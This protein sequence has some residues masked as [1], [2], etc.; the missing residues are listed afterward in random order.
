MTSEATARAQ[1]FVA[2][3]LP[4][5]RGL[6]EGLVELIGYPDEFAA[7][8]RGGL[9]RLADDVYAAEQERVAPG[10]GIVFGVRGPLV[11]AVMRQLRPALKEGSPA[12]A[13]WLAERLAGEEE[14]EFVFFTQLALERALPVDPER[15]WQLMRRLAREASDWIRVDTLAELFAK[16]ILL[17]PLRWAELEQLVYSSSRWE[18]RLVG[19]T[20]ARLP[21]ELPKARRPQL[22]AVPGLDAVGQLIGDAEPDVQKALSWALRSWLEVDGQGVREFIRFEARRS[23]AEDDGHRAWVLRDAL[24]APQIEAPFAKEIRD[25]LAAVRRRPGQPSTS[26]AAAIAGQFAGFEQLTDV[27]VRQQGDRQRMAATSGT[28]G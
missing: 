23:V 4:E 24:T 22:R 21:F 27:A 20:V 18:R 14:R 25:Q 11:A 6:G 15:T 7:A 13:L 19:S 5:A 2:E 3:R 8:L 17:E 10:S 1:A 26:R 9:T 12:L 28:R 16:G